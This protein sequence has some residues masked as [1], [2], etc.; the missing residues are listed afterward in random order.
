MA[1]EQEKLSLVNLRGGVVVERFDDELA[2]VL[3]NIADPNT[4]PAAKR[5]IN[6]KVSFKPD[7]ARD[8]GEVLIVV[9]S[10]LAPAETISTKVF[11]AMTR[12]GP[13]ATE[14]NPNQ[15][16]LPYGE[17]APSGVTQIRPVGG[18]NK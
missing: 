4:P 3:A 8:L 12:S 10:K 17:Q 18:S 7:K 5:E 1:D 2:K 9:T 16:M 6:V 14:Y 13:V 15:P 11:F